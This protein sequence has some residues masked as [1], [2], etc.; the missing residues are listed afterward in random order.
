MTVSERAGSRK[1]HITKEGTTLT[2]IFTC[3][4]TDWEN[5]DSDIPVIG[6]YWEVRPELVVSDIW[7]TWID[8][9]NCE[10]EV[11]YS[12]KGVEFVEKRPDKVSAVKES[13]NF[14]TAVE[15]ANEYIDASDSSAKIWSEVWV[16]AGN[17]E[18]ETPTLYIYR[19]KLVGNIQMFLSK[20]NFNDI[21]NTIGTTNSEDFLKQYVTRFGR[22][23]R[24]IPY[25]ITGDDTGH[26]LFTG[27]R[28]E[29]AGTDNYE[30]NMEFIYS[31]TAWNSPYGVSA[32][33]Y[34]EVNFNTVLPYPTD[35]DNSLNIST[36][37]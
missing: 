10:V 6:D 16:A 21:V 22:K 9:L 7:L 18:D 11:I 12:T 37:R 29:R 24:D 25:D 36:D 23:Y 2:Q 26:W 13:Y 5:E 27:F 35:T 32:N 15:A 3:T 28:S 31:Y 34:R 30:I 14:S 20:W 19:P 4:L 1:M 17:D 33:L 8:N